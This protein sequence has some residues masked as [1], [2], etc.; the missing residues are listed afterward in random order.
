MSATRTATRR[1]GA[2]RDFV[3]ARD[4]VPF[5]ALSVFMSMNPALVPQLALN[6]AVG[7]WLVVRMVRAGTARRYDFHVFFPWLVVLL[8][9]ASTLWASNFAES[10]QGA[11]SFLIYTVLAVHIVSSM[12]V[13]RAIR[14]LSAGFKV[15]LAAS[16]ATIAVSPSTAFVTAIYQ[17]G[18]FQG[19]AS[20]RNYMGYLATLASLFF[21]YEWLSRTRKRLLDVLWIVVA[22][23][24]VVMTRSVTSL[25]LT[26][27]ACVTLLCALALLRSTSRLRGF[28]AFSLITTAGAAAV[29]AFV[30][31]GDVAD[32]LGRDATLTGRTGIWEAVLAYVAREPFFGY[33]WDSVWAVGDAVG[34]GVRGRIG[35]SIS[36]AH[37]GFLN[38]ALQIGWIGAGLVL[39]SVVVGVTTLSRESLRTRSQT[40]LLG[41][42]IVMTI[43]SFNMVE[44]RLTLN[45]GWM[46]F[47][48]FYA[49]ASRSLRAAIATRRG[50]RFAD[51]PLNT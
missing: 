22:I 38:D 26:V 45:T 40:L 19:L 3:E 23:G 44:T 8:I 42:V 7:L 18:S 28:T 37:S 15:I 2:V 32:G 35:F 4:D 21:I 11:L 5:I 31:F 30:N 36:H 39:L 24:V 29:I 51:V 10:A 41:L 9:L 6:A 49:Y 50:G 17:S 12:S 14:G 47:V 13:E 27:L 46:L 43:V 48:L 25:A 1:A 20:H 34:D 16:I 33:G